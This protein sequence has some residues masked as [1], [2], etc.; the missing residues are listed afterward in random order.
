VAQPTYE[1]G[2]IAGQ[3][4]TNRRAS[5]DGS[6]ETVILHT[7]LKVRASSTPRATALHRTDMPGQSGPR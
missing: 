3:L 2:K 6:C 7:T 5:P 4:L 1:M